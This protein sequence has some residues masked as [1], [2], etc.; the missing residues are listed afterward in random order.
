M[1][2]A[3]MQSE[4]ARQSSTTGAARKRTL[5]VGL[6]STGLSAARYLARLGEHVLVIDSRAHPPC[7]D[8]LRA[9][10]PEIRIEL[11]TL[12]PKWLA[13][14]SRVVWSPGLDAA[15]PLAAEAR[16][17]GIELVG[18]IELFARA[19]R[20]P[21][22][23]VT[24]SNG[25]S[26]VTTLTARMLEAAGFA[27]LA[28][29]NLGPPA[30]DLLDGPS[31][32]GT[33]PPDAYVLEISS[34]QME[35]TDSLRP[36]AA[37]VLNVSADHLDRHGDLDRYAALKAKLLAA[38]DHAVFNRDDPLVRS[39]GERC[40]R[41]VPFSTAAA[42]DRGYSIVETNGVR[43]LGRDGKPL[44]PVGELSLRG[45]HNEANALAALALTAT[46]LDSVGAP[47][48]VL[49]AA[50][51]ALTHFEG[52]PH[53]CR[54][55]AVRGGV[56]YID[57]SKGTNVG[58]TVAALGGLPGPLVLIAGGLG[59]SADFA[60]LARAAQGKVKAA[61]L[62]GAAA[63]D[64]EAA[65]AGVCPTRRAADLPAAVH[66]AAG[67]ASPGDTVLLS[68]ACASQDM[69]RDYKH[70]GEVFAAAVRELPQ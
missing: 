63:R 30:L 55:V 26:T 14:A 67:L 12:D 3:M 61:V 50:I 21:V 64:I 8:A 60:P 35:T 43:H 1:G 33:E 70:R 69:F 52:L 18:D 17:R 62:I 57:D 25:K 27:A 29:G 42:L 40:T 65:L 66:A 7:L 10:R 9:E 15:M 2:A 54:P 19:A 37:A 58:A 44:V 6:G 16:R 53:R 48:D 45:L 13:S 51:E 31:E 46:F 32:V 68:P 34:F 41:P 36:L 20:A 24:G 49:D 22:I 5:I 23:A 38:A 59:K 56:E 39:V 47:A 11:E 28:G 4:R